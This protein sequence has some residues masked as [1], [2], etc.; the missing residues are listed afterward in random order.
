MGRGDTRHCNIPPCELDPGALLSSF[1]FSPPNPN[2]TES[3]ELIHR[4][5]S[6]QGIFSYSEAVSGLGGGKRVC[7]ALCNK[8]CCHFP[9]TEC[10]FYVSQLYWKKK[11]VGTFCI[12]V[13][14]NNHLY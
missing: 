14:P 7:F 10:S 1:G 9:G 8:L 11:S 2:L 4:L 6:T 13:H 5:L 3:K 12:E